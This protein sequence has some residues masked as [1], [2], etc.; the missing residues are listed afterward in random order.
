MGHDR[1]NNQ[2]PNSGKERENRNARKR[3]KL[4]AAK[5]LEAPPAPTAVRLQ[6]DRRTIITCRPESIGFWMERYPNASIIQP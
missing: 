5:L 6:L 4:K 1:L 3:N 2:L